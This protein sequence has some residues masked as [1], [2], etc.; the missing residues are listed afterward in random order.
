[1]E[2]HDSRFVSSKSQLNG[3]TKPIPFAWKEYRLLLYTG[4][5]GIVGGLGAQL[6][7]WLLNLAERLLLVGI[8]GYQPPEPGVLNPQS[9]AVCRPVG[10]VADSC[11][12]NSGWGTFWNFGLYL[13]P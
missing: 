11:G 1:M 10:F 8:A 3:V 7:V 5:I 9:F 12:N 4:L 6:F 13:C 2:N